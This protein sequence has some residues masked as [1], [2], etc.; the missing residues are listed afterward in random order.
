MYI[1]FKQDGM[2]NFFST[3]VPIIRPSVVL[4]E[5]GLNSEQISLMT[6]VYIEKYIFGTET[7]G[8]N[9]KGGL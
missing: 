2:M 4:V 3:K 1:I 5:S 8:L 7:S 9:N 6:P